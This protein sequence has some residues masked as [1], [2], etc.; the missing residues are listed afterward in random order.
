MPRQRMAGALPQENYFN[1]RGT[2]VPRP[3]FSQ[4]NLITDSISIREALACLDQIAH[5]RGA[6]AVLFQSARHL[7]ASTSEGHKIMGKEKISI[8]EALACLD[9]R[10]ENTAS[11]NI[12]SIREALAC[13]DVAGRHEWGVEW[14]ISIREA[15]ACL[16]FGNWYQEA[17]QGLFQSARHLRASTLFSGGFQDGETFQ[18][19][20]H[21]RAS[22]V[23][24]RFIRQQLNISIRE[25]LAC[26]DEYEATFDL[27]YK[28]ISIREAL[29][30]LD[31]GGDFPV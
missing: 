30:C 29:A 18:S 1:P 13:L 3:H 24:F 14:G 27:A 15:L 16:D 20:R 5:V 2:C 11:K 23:K 22:T 26:L 10:E 4:I 8:R 21:L 31:G 17:L 25:A 6:Y 9:K 28:N 19:A 12:I 7:R